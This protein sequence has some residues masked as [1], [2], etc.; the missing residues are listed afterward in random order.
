MVNNGADINVLGSGTTPL[1]W[2]AA[3]ENNDA[4]L[5]LINQGADGRLSGA[6][7][8][9]PIECFQEK[10]G[11]ELGPLYGKYSTSIIAALLENPETMETGKP[12][13]PPFPEASLSFSGMT[14]YLGQSIINIS[15]TNSGKGNLFG[16]A[17]DI[18]IS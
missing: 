17:A 14:N 1:Y 9:T 8:P 12:E 15:V 13:L 11:I 16:L 3:R 6:N 4:A 2:A 7:H 5:Y 18:N 10:M